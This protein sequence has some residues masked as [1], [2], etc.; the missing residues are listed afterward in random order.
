MVKDSS[1]HMLNSNCALVSKVKL[2]APLRSMSRQ[3]KEEEKHWQRANRSSRV[4]EE[5][6]SQEDSGLGVSR[7][8]KC[9]SGRP[10]YGSGGLYVCSR[11]PKPRSPLAVC[12]LKTDCIN[13]TGPGRE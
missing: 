4:L 7:D 9:T 1:S 2:A 6:P 8:F 11:K 12:T 3:Q 13:Q 5:N 10:S